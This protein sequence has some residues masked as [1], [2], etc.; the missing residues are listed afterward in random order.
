MKKRI[1]LGIATLSTLGIGIASAAPAPK[2]TICHATS[3]AKNA[4]V[5]TVV[6]GNATAGHFDNKGTAKAGHEGDLLLQGDVACPTQNVSTPTNPT[7]PTQPETPS[8]P[9]G[10]VEGTTTTLPEPIAGK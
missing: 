2:V 3:S 8:T 5:R 6:S 7:T 4:Y 10:S 9:T 1:L